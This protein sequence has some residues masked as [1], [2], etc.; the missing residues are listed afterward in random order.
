MVSFM[1]SH[2]QTKLATEYKR[3][4]KKQYNTKQNQP[5]II[6]MNTKWIL[7]FKYIYNNFKLETI[8]NTGMVRNKNNKGIHG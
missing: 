3:H 7:H 1:K 6:N 5:Y 4:F 2:T 8:M